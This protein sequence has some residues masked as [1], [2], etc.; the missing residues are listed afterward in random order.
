M[1]TP[2]LGASYFEGYYYI[3]KPLLANTSWADARIAAQALGG[4]GWDLATIYSQDEQNFIQTLL[5]PN[6]REL[7]GIHE[8]WIAGEQPSESPEPGG[9]WQW[10]T[11]HAVFYNNAPIDGFFTNWGSFD[12]GPGNEPNQ[13]GIENHLALD[14][15]YGWGWNDNDSNLDGVTLGYVAKRAAP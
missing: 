13:T 12:T 1:Y 2:P 5:P 7:G 15:R 4:I 6:P 11:D 14:N 9:N 8:Y 10:A 3:V